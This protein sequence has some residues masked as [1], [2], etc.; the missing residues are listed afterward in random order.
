MPDEHH[1]ADTKIY[2]AIREESVG[3]NRLWGVLLGGLLTIV[4]GLSVS[5]SAQAATSNVAVSADP[6]EEKAV[7][8]TISGQ[9]EANLK[10]WVV[11]YPVTRTTGTS[12]PGDDPFDLLTSAYAEVLLRED[13]LVAGSY[14]RTATFTPEDAGSYLACSYVAEGERNA[15]TAKASR[16]FQVREPNVTSTV[17]SSADPTEGVPV[18]VTVSGQTEVNRK[19]WVVV[20]PARNPS[21]P[22]DD[23]F[24][25]LTTAYTS[26]LVREDPVPAGNYR[27]TATFT[28]EQA[29]PYLVCSYVAEGERAEANAKVTKALEVRRKGA[30]MSVTADGPFRHFSKSRFSVEG[31]TEVAGELTTYIYRDTQPCPAMPDGKSAKDPVEPGKFESRGW[32]IVPDVPTR[33]RVCVYLSDRDGEVVAVSSMEVS[34]KR[35]PAFMPKLITR[36]GKVGFGGPPTLKWKSGIGPGTATDFVEMFRR[37]PRPSSRPMKVNLDSV[38]F[39]G[40]YR[41][42]FWSLSFDR[43]YDWGYGRWWW[44]IRRTTATGYSETSRPRL[45]IS[46]PFRR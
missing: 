29:G 12:C 4:L 21:C 36:R 27:R 18:T 3:K 9:A 20:M 22:G 43:S 37:K 35:N 45:V 38:W 5:G 13:P 15:A 16:T 25:L 39:S 11:V 32:W 46:A 41:A 19:L 28:P 14:G 33:S 10:L 23:P 24:D 30:L 17:T 44:R 42:G 26:I 34:V 8:L 2:L 1:E 7:T 6:T 31:F 40:G